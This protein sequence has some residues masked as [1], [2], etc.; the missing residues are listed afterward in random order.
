M[1]INNHGRCGRPKICRTI[2]LSTDVRIFEPSGI[3]RCKREEVSLTLDELEAVRWADY[4]KAS[5]EEGA[6]SMGVSRQTFGNIIGSARTKIA[7][8]LINRKAIRIEGGPIHKEEEDES[9][10]SG[11]RK[12]R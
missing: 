7:D 2:R 6:R 12:K 1:P 5:Q 3:R 8:A 11:F 10:N 4:L 9:S